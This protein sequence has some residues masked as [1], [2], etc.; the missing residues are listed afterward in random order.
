[1]IYASSTN[2]LFAGLPSPS[3]QDKETILKTTVSDVAKQSPGLP[4]SLGQSQGVV[5]AFQ[6]VL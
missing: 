4:L 5:W 1:M 3:E 6:D 2:F